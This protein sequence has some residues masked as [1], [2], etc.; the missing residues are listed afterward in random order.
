M[1][2]GLASQETLGP[3]PRE[4][5]VS[6]AQSVTADTGDHRER[7]MTTLRDKSRS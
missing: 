6:V 3:Q 5:G 4:S 7:V 2:A 1:S